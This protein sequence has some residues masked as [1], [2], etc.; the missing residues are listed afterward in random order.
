[1]SDEAADR[2]LIDDR[3]FVKEKARVARERELHEARLALLRR[4]DALPEDDQRRPVVQEMI[5]QLTEQEATPPRMM[6]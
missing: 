3:H 6:N 2:S 1:M 5:Q 4:F